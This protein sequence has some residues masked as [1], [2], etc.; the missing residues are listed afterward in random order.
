MHSAKAADT[1]DSGGMGIQHGYSEGAAMEA[2]CRMG[3]K[4]WMSGPYRP[5]GLGIPDGPFPG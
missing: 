1:T 3:R 5:S 2:D 4:E